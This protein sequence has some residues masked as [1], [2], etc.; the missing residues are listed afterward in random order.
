MI[1]AKKLNIPADVSEKH[2]IVE[3]EV[4]RKGADAKGLR[5]ACYEIGTRGMDELIT[6]RRDLKKTDGKVIP[7]E[8]MPLFLQAVSILMLLGSRH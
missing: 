1:G 6:A 2:N 4:Y 3:E 5:D 8:A 7:K